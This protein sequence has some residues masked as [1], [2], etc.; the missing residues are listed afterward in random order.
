MRWV[1]HKYQ[2]KASAATGGGDN[3]SS[4]L[5]GIWATNH[6]GTNI[7]CRFIAKET[8]RPLFCSEFH[9]SARKLDSL[10]LNICIPKYFD[11]ASWI[12]HQWP[13]SS[14]GARLFHSASLQAIF[15]ISIWILHVS[16][17]SPWCRN[18]TQVRRGPKSRI[19]RYSCPNAIV[20]TKW[21]WCWRTASI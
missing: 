14:D 20:E 13:D 17:Q 8:S 16:I 10:Q 11:S 9:Q 12:R 15:F 19:S 6:D 18:I 3:L 4:A 5:F 7:R 21:K 2:T 1:I